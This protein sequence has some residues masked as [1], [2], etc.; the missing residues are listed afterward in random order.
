MEVPR[1]VVQRHALD[2]A[3]RV[4]PIAEAVGTRRPGGIGAAFD[5]DA[6]GQRVGVVPGAVLLHLFE[7]LPFRA[8][9]AV[10]AQQDVG[11]HE[12]R[13]VPSRRGAGEARIVVG[14]AIRVAGAGRP[15]RQLTSGRRL[16]LAN[17]DRPFG[18]EAPQIE[19]VAVARRHQLAVAGVAG[20]LVDRRVRRHAHQVAQDR[21][22]RVAHDPIEQAIGAL[23][24]ADLPRVRMP[25]LRTEHRYIRRGRQPLHFDVLEALV[26]ELGAPD[27]AARAADV[28]VG[29]IV[30][31]QAVAWDQAVLD[32]A[33]RPELLPVAQRDLAPLGQVGVE[34]RVTGDVLPKV[35]QI[36]ARLRLAH[37]AEREL[38]LRADRLDVLRF[39][40]PGR[41]R[42]RASAAPGG[43]VV[44]R[45]G[46]PGQARRRDARR[47]VSP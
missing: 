36:H 43:I 37:A 34:D 27:I 47:S 39:E 41:P 15:D 44:F 24:R 40:H 4:R 7:R 8:L 42:R 20:L 28:A 6:V 32:A 17:V 38:L 10:E 25:D 31:A 5:E 16:R 2:G 12:Q 29:L 18:V 23:E 11:N 45:R 30:H 9:V 13:R 33:V 1:R 26:G 14:R 22:A 21:A 35:E 46:P 19:Q 3:G